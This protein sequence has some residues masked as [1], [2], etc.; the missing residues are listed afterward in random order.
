MINSI[1]IQVGA[2]NYNPKDV[3]FDIGINSIDDIV[4]KNLK[5]H[6]LVNNS[7]IPWLECFLEKFGESKLK[8]LKSIT[9]RTNDV[10]AFEHYVAHKLKRIE[11]GGGLVMKGKKMLMIYRLGKWDLPKGKIEKGESIE[12]G[13]IREVEEECGIKVKIVE[14]LDE[15]WHTYHQKKKLYIKRTHWYLMECLSD[16]DISPQLEEFIEKVEWKTEKQAKDLL[17]DTYKNI[18]KVIKDFYARIA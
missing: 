18:R 6:V 2:K 15:T 4:D 9:F 13:A 16:K 5:G 12:E 1:P 8:K 11:A 7:E 17:K 10:A 3:Q 14:K